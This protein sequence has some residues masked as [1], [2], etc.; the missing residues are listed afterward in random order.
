A[1][2]RKSIY[3]FNSISEAEE[4]SEFTKENGLAN[5]MTGVTSSKHRINTSY[6][7]YD[8]ENYPSILQ[9][10]HEENTDGKSS[11]F[12]TKESDAVAFVA[13]NSQVKVS[14]TAKELEQDILTYLS[15]TEDQ[16]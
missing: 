2:L 5:L 4:G 10:F 11:F 16:I 7:T 6:S 13:N 8:K 3:S 9:R 1:L 12:T 14:N 15:T